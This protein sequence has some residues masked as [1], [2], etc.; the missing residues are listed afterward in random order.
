MNR[1]Q[2]ERQRQTKKI[3]KEREKRPGRTAENT[4]RLFF[5]AKPETERG[6]AV[7]SGLCPGKAAGGGSVRP[8]PKRP[9]GK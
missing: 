5:Y 9:G 3:K 2:K 1:R 4:V 8:A 7:I 6:G